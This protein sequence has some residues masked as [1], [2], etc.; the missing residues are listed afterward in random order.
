M[1]SGQGGAEPDRFPEVGDGFSPAA[2]DGVQKADFV[3]NQGVAGGCG[4]GLFEEGERAL[5][6]AFGLPSKGLLAESRGRLSRAG[7]KSDCGEAEYPH[8]VQYIGAK[9]EGRPADNRTALWV[10]SGG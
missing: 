4:S 5:R 2:E 6:I 8:Q 9:R 7:C 10:A 3:A 1:G